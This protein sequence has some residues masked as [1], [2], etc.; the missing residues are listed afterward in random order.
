MKF[1]RR[2]AIEIVAA[3]CVFVVG[4]AILGWLAINILVPMVQQC[5]QY[6]GRPLGE[7]PAQCARYFWR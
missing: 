5:Q 1:H 4:L 6:A 7:V 2:D 3:I